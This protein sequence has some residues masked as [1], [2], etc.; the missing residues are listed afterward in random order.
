MD[1]KLARG[2]ARETF[3]R[4]TKLSKQESSP[5][6]PVIAKLLQTYL[7][8]GGVD[9]SRLTDLAS[10][11]ASA[12]ASTDGVLVN[13]R[14]IKH[15]V[16]S[17]VIVE[18]TSPACVGGEE[19]PWLVARSDTRVLQRNVLKVVETV[20]HLAV[21]Q[22]AVFRIFQR[23]DMRNGFMPE[24]LDCATLWTPALLF[25]LFGL[26]ARNS[27]GDQIE[28]AIPFADGLL[29]GR[30]EMN[31][32]D[33]P[34][35]GP[36]ITEFRRGGHKIRR[37]HAPFQVGQNVIPIVSINTY[38]GRYELFDNQRAIL[39]TFEDFE[40]RYRGAMMNMR[41]M[42][43]LGYA[44]EEV[45]RLLGPVQFNEIDAQTLFELAANAHAFFESPEW[46]RH[47][48]AHR[49]RPRFLQ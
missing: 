38:V 32:L 37:V 26:G 7:I 8:D 31:Y 6:T 43:A 34:E 9:E 40:H 13:S 5:T 24:L 29:L 11:L 42:C 47:A 28:V 48:E 39:D 33:G 18:A 22:H 2:L 10:G 4:L 12:L 41:R 20:H 46:K 19:Q 21:A 15:P 23:G 1:E 44:D 27:R 3:R 36:T 45:T 17:K 25:T 30:I 35:Q 16:K 14:L 49:P